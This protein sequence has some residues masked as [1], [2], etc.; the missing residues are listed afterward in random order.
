MWPDYRDWG[1]CRPA[2][3]KSDAIQKTATRR[4]KQTGQHKQHPINTN[5][6]PL[7]WSHQQGG[8]ESPDQSW[9]L[10]GGWG[11][12][13]ITEEDAVHVR[14]YLFS[15]KLFFLPLFL[16]P[17]GAT[18]ALQPQR[19]WDLRAFIPLRVHVLPRGEKMETGWRFWESWNFL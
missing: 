7:T 15:P 13:G 11:R 8:S 3:V 10:A 5:T 16:S 9:A 2:E 14:N 1:S 19:S 17:A 18:H 6:A 12:I 4:S